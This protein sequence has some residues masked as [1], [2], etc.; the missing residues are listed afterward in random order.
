[1][2]SMNRAGRVRGALLAGLAMSMGAGDA[3]AQQQP[4]API[5][6]GGGGGSGLDE[7]RA[8]GNEPGWS[9]VLSGGRVTLTTGEGQRTAWA[10]LP[11]AERIDPVTV[12]YA[13]IAEGRPLVVTVTDALCADTMTGM[14]HPRQ[15]TV[16]HDGRTLV[17]CGGEPISLLRRREWK[18]ATIAGRPVQ[19]GAEPTL[20]FGA[21]NRV[22]G[23]ASCNRFGA[24]FKLTGEGLSIERAFSTMM[25]CPQPLME[26]EAL[27]LDILA[28]VVRF[29]LEPD[30]ALV[31]EATDGRAIVARPG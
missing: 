9:L 27:F 5:P 23:M 16:E 13:A 1:M 25:A 17:G 3:A 8:R 19:A 12:R 10:P 20:A 31:L 11:V 6:N 28:K 2:I 26:Q 15:V 29:R 30:G 22:T 7:L 14:P 4:G 24:G 18:V 21:D